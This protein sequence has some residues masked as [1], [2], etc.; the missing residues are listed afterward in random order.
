MD[1]K[2]RF[3]QP[4][5]SGFFVTTMKPDFKG[6]LN[7]DTSGNRTTALANSTLAARNAPRPRAPR[8]QF[9]TIKLDFAIFG[10]SGFSI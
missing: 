8:T 2:P 9:N 7:V 4:Q 1:G 3:F 5:S 10:Q 6:G